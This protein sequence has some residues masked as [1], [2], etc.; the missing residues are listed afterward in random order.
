M[1]A[2]PSPEVGSV[3]GVRGA[4]G[5]GVYTS[6]MASAG[7]CCVASTSWAPRAMRL[8][9]CNSEPGS[10][11]PASPRL[12]FIGGF[13]ALG[14]GVHIV[15]GGITKCGNT[16]LFLASVPVVLAGIPQMSS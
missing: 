12:P 10:A 15:P 2:P 8:A 6:V 9:E 4:R 14:I 1:Q 11:E 5:A 7:M 3:G 16:K 13:G